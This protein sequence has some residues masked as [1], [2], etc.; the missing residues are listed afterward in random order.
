M[1]MQAQDIGLGTTWV[2]AFD[3]VKARESF[4]IPDNLEILAL[5][6]TGYPA[7]DAE[8]NPMHNTFIDIHEMVSYNNF[9]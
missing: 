6:P 8:I 5:L 4:S 7:E 1:M 3:P 2:M 9:N